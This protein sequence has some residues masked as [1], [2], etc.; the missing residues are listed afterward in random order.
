MTTVDERI[1]IL[2]KKLQEA[3]AKKQKIE[4]MKKAIDRAWKKPIMAA[5]LAGASALFTLPP[6]AQEWRFGWQQLQS[7]GAAG[8]G[9]LPL[10]FALRLLWLDQ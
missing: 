4:A 1:A 5:L 2:Q 3:K 10:R 8:L 7:H 9:L 6:V